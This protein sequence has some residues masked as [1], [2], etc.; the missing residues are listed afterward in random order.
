M[1]ESGIPLG[2]WSGSDAVD[3]LHQ[4]VADFN[5]TA[6][7][8]TAVM[9]RLTRVLVALTVVLVIGLAVQIALAV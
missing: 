9:I 5:A 1:A 4:S 8:Q 3:A 7:E 6:G 2:Q